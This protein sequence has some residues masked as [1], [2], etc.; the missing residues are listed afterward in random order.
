MHNVAVI[1]AGVWAENHRIGWQARDD[2][3]TPAW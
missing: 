1:G 3:R 2:A